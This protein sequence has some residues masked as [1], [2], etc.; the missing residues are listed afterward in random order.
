MDI[1]TQFKTTFERDPQILV[2]APGRVNLIGEHVDYNQGAVMPIA[3]DRYVTLAAAPRSD[4][5]IHLFA[6]DFK[7]DVSFNLNSINSKNDLN[8]NLLP[9]WALYPA[10][11][12]RE[13][14]EKGYHPSGVDVLYKSTIPSGA[15]LSSSAAIEVAFALLWNKL[16][17]WSIPR[18]D[19][20]QLCQ[21]A[22]N[23]YVG[24]ACGLMDQFASLFGVAD[25][26]IYF[27]TRSLEW[28]PLPLPPNT[29]IVIADTKERHQLVDSAYNDRRNACKHV[30]KRLQEFNPKI[31]S[32]RDI[33]IVEFAAY[34][35]F[36]PEKDQPCAEHV[37]R[38]IFRVESVRNALKRE[39]EKALEA[40][41]YASHTSLQKLYKVSTPSLD[42]LVEL[43]R[44]IPGGKGS[45]MTGAG[46]GGC[47]INLVDENRAESFMHQLKSRYE[48]V[49]G[50]SVD[51]FICHAVDGA[52]ITQV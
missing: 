27:D 25:H 30:V 31:Q 49:T 14:H 12:V 34:S 48:K 32:L 33:S 36:L 43:S 17:D 29:A 38:E 46:F 13:L 37:V 22:E 26:A 15:G 40:L 44:D 9:H 47:T 52:K 35:E 10:G 28:E 20:A 8:G 2:H 41:L 21:Q 24:V 45:R 42:K 50:K 11:V 23:N 5:E 18:M 6:A 51:V 7:Q 4:D 1:Q 19:L 16:G 39:D 3:I